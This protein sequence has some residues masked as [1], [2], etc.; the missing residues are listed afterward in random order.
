MHDRQY[1][2]SKVGKTIPSNNKHHIHPKSP[3][4]HPRTILVDEEAHKAY[5]RIFGNPKSYEDACF[6]LKR[7]WFP[8][9]H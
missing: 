7:D 3:D 5:H 8:P 2:N 4:K 9:K 1:T 6:I